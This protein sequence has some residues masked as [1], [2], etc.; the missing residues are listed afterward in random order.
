M[1]KFGSRAMAECGGAGALSGPPI[2]LKVRK[3][4]LCY[5][6]DYG[7]RL[8]DMEQE[9]S[10]LKGVAACRCLEEGGIRLLLVPDGKES[11]GRLGRSIALCCKQKMNRFHL[12]S[13]VEFCA[14][15]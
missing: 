6:R 12:P 14:K 15:L 4:A 2:P 7:V 10:R 5:I 11:A 8:G 1:E 13:A 3:E 9:L